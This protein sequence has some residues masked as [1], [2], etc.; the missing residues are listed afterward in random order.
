[1]TLYFYTCHPSEYFYWKW[2][3]KMAKNAID[4][5]TRL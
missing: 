1:M 2:L 5:P 3:M 4:N